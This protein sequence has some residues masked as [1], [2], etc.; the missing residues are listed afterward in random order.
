MVRLDGADVITERTT[1]VVA[2]ASVSSPWWLSHVS[3]I[4]GLLLPVAGVIW[5]AV[6]I[7]AKIFRGTPDK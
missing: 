2:I 7:Y 3:E 1:D 4:A 6:Q 5:L